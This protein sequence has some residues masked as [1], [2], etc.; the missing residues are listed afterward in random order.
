MELIGGFG[1]FRVNHRPG[2]GGPS[3]EMWLAGVFGNFDMNHPHGGGGSTVE[4]TFG[5]NPWMQDVLEDMNGTSGVERYFWSFSGET[6][7]GRGVRHIWGKFMDKRRVWRH[8]R[9]V[10]S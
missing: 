1:L 8:K 7:P 4:G 9:H 2:G 6:P 3:W 5:N 10:W